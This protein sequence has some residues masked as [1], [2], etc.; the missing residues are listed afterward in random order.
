MFELEGEPGAKWGHL[1]LRKRDCRPG[2]RVNIV[3]HPFGQPKQIS[4]QN[5]LVEYVGGDVIQ[6]VT[7]TNPGSSGSPV[8]ND[9]W[10]VVGL[11]HSG[12][13]LPEPTTGQYYN[14]NEGILIAQILADLPP[15]IREEIDAA[16]G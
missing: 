7:S 8:L 16:A 2:E 11:H 5:N 14:R 1:P 10:Q 3:Q 9:Q 15:G 4:I 13:N 6:Y 12:G